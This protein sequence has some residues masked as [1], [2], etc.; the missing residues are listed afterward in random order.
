MGMLAMV[1]RVT[2]LGKY[3]ATRKVAGDKDVPNVIS[4]SVCRWYL[5]RRFLVSATAPLGD[6]AVC[7]GRFS[8]APVLGAAKAYWGI[9]CPMS[10]SPRILLCLAKFTAF[11]CAMGVGCS[12][13]C[14]WRRLRPTSSCGNSGSV[15][16]AIRCLHN[17]G[18]S[19]SYRSACGVPGVMSIPVV[20]IIRHG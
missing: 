7:A 12:L 14:A 11:R 3:S 5:Q 18:K 4:L 8:A 2:I 1:Q 20:L 16:M 19:G 17:P 9:S 15:G 13:I 10:L 6:F